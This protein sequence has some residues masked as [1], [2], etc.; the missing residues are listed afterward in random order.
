MIEYA[1]ELDNESIV[2][3]KYRTLNLYIVFDDPILAKDWTF[4]MKYLLKTMD[5]NYR[6]ATNPLSNEK[7]QLAQEMTNQASNLIVRKKLS[8]D[9][10]I[11]LNIYDPDK[12]AKIWRDVKYT[13]WALKGGIN[14]KYA[15]YNRNYLEFEEAI[16]EIK[17]PVKNEHLVTDLIINSFVNQ[18]EIDE[19][20]KECFSLYS[21]SQEK[22]KK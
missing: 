16:N 8:E 9:F 11:L 20:Y 2:Y 19:F 12:D 7:K 18:L 17:A 14:D 1:D 22:L 4:G 10:R 6:G 13:F 21:S 3:L 5:I 15:I